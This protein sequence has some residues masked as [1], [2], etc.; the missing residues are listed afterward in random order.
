MVHA[1]IEISETACPEFH[2]LTV[3]PLVAHTDDQRSRDDG[4][5]LTQWMRVRRDLVAIGHLEADGVIAA[6]GHGVALENSELSASRNE[7]RRR[8]PLHLIW[9]ECILR[10]G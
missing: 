9:R 2:R 4:Y 6:R 8:T 1:G 3:V 5:I 7:R 10:Q